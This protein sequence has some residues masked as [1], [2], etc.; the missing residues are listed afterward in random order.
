MREL[1]AS[2]A[3]GEPFMFRARFAHSGPLPGWAKSDWFYKKNLAGGGAMLDMGIHAIDQALWHIGPVKFVQAKAETLRKKI[4]VDDNALLLLEFAGGKALGYIEIGW[5][6]PAGFNGYDIIGDEG[7]IHIDYAGQ[8]VLT[9][10]KITPDTKARHKL[11]RRVVDPEPTAGGWRNEVTEVVRA[12]K[13][14]SDL[15]I[16]IDK[17]GAAL[18]VALAAYQSSQTGKRVAVA[19]VK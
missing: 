13:R 4:E 19:S 16:D 10:G 15:G 12:M 18:Q 7:W 11:K 9:T 3:I 8:L 14:G 5:T 6:S 17:G 1:I 2:G